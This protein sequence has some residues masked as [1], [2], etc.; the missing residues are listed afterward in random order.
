MPKKDK[1]FVKELQTVQQQGNFK[2]SQIKKS[3]SAE[4][5]KPPSKSNPETQEKDAQIKALT[6]QISRIK[7]EANQSI[8]FESQKSQNYLEQITKLTAEVDTKEQ[9]IK[10]LTTEK[11]QLTDQ[12]NELRINNLKQGNYFTKYQTESKL[13]NQLKLQLAKSQKDLTITQQ[14]L[15]KAQNYLAQITKLTAEVDTKEQVIKE[16]TTE[17]NELADQNSELRINNLKQDN[18]FT[19]YQTES[20]LT[21]QL[22]LQLAKSQK[23][24]AITQQD[25]KKAQRIIELR[26]LNLDNNKD[27][28]NPFDY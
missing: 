22:K 5:L 18:Y 16:L 25:L 15:K 1:D 19:K 11:N 21:Q 26:T 20:K 24:L 6:E 8:K 3:R 4:D 23:D 17:K 10:E 28:E 9:A 13:T 2:P 27:Q 7:K 14:D 12:N